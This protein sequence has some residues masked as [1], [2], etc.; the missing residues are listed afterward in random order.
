MERI[1]VIGGGLAGFEAIV[2]L[3][4][5]GYR[6]VLT[7]VSAEPHLPY[8]RPPLSKAVLRGEANRSDLEADWEELDVEV[9]LDCRATRLDAGTV[10]T[11]EGRVDFDGLVIATGSSPISLADAARGE[12]VCYLRTIDDAVTLRSALVTGARI[13]IVGAGWVGAEV[14]TA[15]AAVGCRVTV[16][17][18]LDRPL[19]A[20]LPPDV[21]K[22][23]ESWYATAGVELRLGASVVGVEPGGVHLATGERLDADCVLVGI[24]VRPETSWLA[25][26]GVT[27]DERGCVRVGASL[28]TAMPGVVAAGDC[29]V[30]DS[31]RF[32]CPLHVEHWDNALRAPAV[33]AATLLGGEARYDPVP[34]FWSEQFGHVVQY[35]GHYPGADTLLF[36]GDP[37]EPAWTA[38]WLRDGLLVAALAVDR[39]RDLAQSRRV[40]GERRP[41]DAARLRDPAVAIVDAVEGD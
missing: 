40:I 35:V 18:A 22:W 25:G 20:A 13:V 9:R 1:V 21:G 2:A 27:L 5:H 19:G 16:V 23:T 32:G 33:A 26:S 14:A 34:Y 10:E 17:E 39:P 12:N 36:R 24:G 28:E 7:L 29:T 11:E 8:D 38:C 4:E 30:W 15:A 41:V 6:G 3:R 37:S 31:A